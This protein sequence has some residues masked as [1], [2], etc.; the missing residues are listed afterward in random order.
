MGQLPCETE[1]GRGPKDFEFFS[2]SAHSRVTWKEVRVLAEQIELCSLLRT[3]NT[4]VSETHI[5]LVSHC[6]TYIRQPNRA[7]PNDR[8]VEHFW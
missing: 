6:Y 7:A 3:K 5:S 8:D 1:E 2:A 4:Y